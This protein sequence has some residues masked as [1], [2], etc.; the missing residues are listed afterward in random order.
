MTQIAIFPRRQKD[1]ASSCR[2]LQESALGGGLQEAGG[3]GGAEVE[4]PAEPRNPAATEGTRRGTLGVFQ[5]K[6]VTEATG[7]P[8]RRSR[9]GHQPTAH[10]PR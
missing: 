7:L 5:A 6:E 1:G 4:L 8:P 2:R 9:Q 3:M 10:C